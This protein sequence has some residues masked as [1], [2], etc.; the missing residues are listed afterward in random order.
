MDG[1]RLVSIFLLPDWGWLEACL[2]GVP[3]SVDPISCLDDLYDAPSVRIP[4]YDPY[5]IAAEAIPPD[6][7]VLS[8][9]E[10]VGLISP[11]LH[12]VWDVSVQGAC[13]LVH[14]I[15]SAAA[16]Q[17]TI[18]DRDVAVCGVLNLALGIIKQGTKRIDWSDGWTG[19]DGSNL[20][21]AFFGNDSASARRLKRSLRW[22]R[23][24]LFRQFVSD[25]RFRRG[26]ARVCFPTHSA[27]SVGAV[28]LVGAR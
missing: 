8:V 17:E 18:E 15:L 27:M 16:L 23:N 14:L 20:P 5:R 22:V 7:N 21:Q 9:E 24:S 3:Y 28:S 4:A 13:M 1:I 6:A 12:A 2:N 10:I 11:I 19:L 26:E 25:E